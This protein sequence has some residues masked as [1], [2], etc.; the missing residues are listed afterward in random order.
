MHSCKTVQG[1]NRTGQLGDM[2]LSH[3]VGFDLFVFIWL[4]IH[5]SNVFSL[6]MDFFKFRLV[7]SFFFFF[8]SLQCFVRM[9]RE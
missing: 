2:T 3:F 1:V 9:F 7:L 8:S 5:F 4:L 6:L